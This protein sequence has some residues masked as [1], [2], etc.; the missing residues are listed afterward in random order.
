VAKALRYM[1]HFKLLPADNAAKADLE[2]VIKAR[3]WEKKK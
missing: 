2:A 3:D 1:T